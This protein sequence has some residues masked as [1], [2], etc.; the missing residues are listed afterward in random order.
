[1]VSQDLDLFVRACVS[2]RRCYGSNTQFCPDCF[3][4]LIG[5]ELIPFI[6]DSR[7]QLIKVLSRGGMG[8]VF[9][10]YD[11]E[12]RQEVAIKVFRSSAMADP[13]AQDRFRHEVEFAT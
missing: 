9:S 2:C 11:R 13:R 8:V 7:F 6:V 4:E 3:V 1:M 12:T 10:A 5:I